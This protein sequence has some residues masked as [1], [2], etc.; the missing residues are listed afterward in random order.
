MK[1][2]KSQEISQVFEKS[3]GIKVGSVKDIE[4]GMN[5][6]LW[7]V[8]DQKGKSY[9]LKKYVRDERD[10]LG[11]EY[12]GIKIMRDYGITSVPEAYWCDKEKLLAVYSFE[13]G[14]KKKP[15][16]L[17]SIEIVKMAGFL[18]KLKKISGGKET[19]NFPLS[20]NPC[21]SLNDYLKNINSRLEGLNRNIV[22][23][24]PRLLKYLRG[25]EIKPLFNQMIKKCLG[26][27]TDSGKLYKKISTSFLQLCPI[28]FGPHNMLISKN[29][30][31]CF[32]DFEYFGM[33]DPARVLA[34]FKWHEISE[35]ISDDKKK[36]FR[37]TYLTGIHATK[38]FVC[39]LNLVEKIAEIDWMSIYLGSVSPKKINTRRFC[40]K[41][42]NEENYVVNQINKFYHRLDKYY[43]R[44][45]KQN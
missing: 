36:L 24:N 22:I 18:V 23:N 3:L 4:G 8:I 25:V 28:D 11:H 14:I 32:L 5:N 1:T 42:F 10:R 44:N 34:D 45:R 40:D 16:E 7:K 15:E 6:R 43:D 38:D 21:L 41:S 35:K 33:D 17:T 2:L 19:R 27:K 39:H 26:S 9:L 20:V 30:K 37:T 12:Q 29:G 13:G 31:I